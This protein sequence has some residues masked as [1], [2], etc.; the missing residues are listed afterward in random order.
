MDKIHMASL[1]SGKPSSASTRHQEVGEDSTTK[2]L[3]NFYHR[4]MY[5]ARVRYQKHSLATEESTVLQGATDSVQTVKP[6]SDLRPESAFTTKSSTHNLRLKTTE[7]SISSKKMNMQEQ[8]RAT[9]APAKPTLPTEK[10]RFPKNYKPC[11]ITTDQ[12]WNPDQSK[13]LHRELLVE[14]EHISGFMHTRG[15]KRAQSI[16]KKKVQMEGQIDCDRFF[17]SV[18]SKGLEASHCT[19]SDFDE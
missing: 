18:V 5:E 11:L 1:L 16:P 19:V 2:S 14:A 6:K 15:L 12:Y 13:E 3:L 17:G 7:G 8:S 9:D 4:P 10:S